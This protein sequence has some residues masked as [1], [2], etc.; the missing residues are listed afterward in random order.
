MLLIADEVQ[1]GFGRTGRWLAIDHTG[2]LPDILIMAKAL[3]SGLPL[4]GIAATPETMAKWRPGS[5]GG[6][7]GGNIVACAA[8]VATLQAMRDEGMIDNAAAMGEVLMSGL[9]HLQE[10]HPEIGDVRGLGLM[11]GTE[12]TSPKGEPWTERAKAV[13]DACLDGDLMLLTCGP[14]DNT[15]RWI[16]PLIVNESQIHH[17]LSIFE[18][19]LATA[20]G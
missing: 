19:A 7:Y 10:E 8:G 18:Q 15:I 17:A 1:S 3:A 11:V 5:H 20:A 2:V 9:R 6:T 14:Y 16:P 4:S 12:F 13:T